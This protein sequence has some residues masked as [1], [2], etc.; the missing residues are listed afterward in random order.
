MNIGGA[1]SAYADYM[2]SQASNNKA[3]TLQN[4]L[5]GSGT[6]ADEKELKEACKEFESYFVEQVFNAMMETTK[7]FSDDEDDGYA[8]KMVDYFKDFAVQELCGKVTDG[9]GLGLANILYEQMKRN[10]GIGVVQPEA[11]TEE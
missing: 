3:Q 1:G 10:Y 11:L 8:T 9:E 2:T 4:K 5:A 6:S 7:V